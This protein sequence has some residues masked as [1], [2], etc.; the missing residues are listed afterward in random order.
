MEDDIKSGYDSEQGSCYDS[1]D[2]FLDDSELVTESDRWSTQRTTNR[3]DGAYDGGAAEDSPASCSHESWAFNMGSQQSPWDSGGSQGSQ[4][5]NQLAEGR[6]QDAVAPPLF[7][8]H[9]PYQGEIGCRV[10]AADDDPTVE[11]ITGMGFSANAAKKA[12]HACHGNPDMAV[13]WIFGHREHPTLKD[14]SDPNADP[15]DAL[16]IDIQ[17]QAANVEGAQTAQALPIDADAETQD[18]DDD[19]SFDLGADDLFA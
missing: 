11:M 5:Q 13:E 9:Q 1:D 14:P 2:S 4:G 10:L 7:Q 15:T 16:V 3:S 18:L 17:H 12:L 19:T 8:F 6:R